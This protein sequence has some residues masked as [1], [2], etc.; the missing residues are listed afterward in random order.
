MY[1]STPLFPAF[2]RSC[3]RDVNPIPYVSAP[4]V[5][6]RPIADYGP[7]ANTCIPF[8]YQPKQ[9]N[10]GGLKFYYL[11][12]PFPDLEGNLKSHPGKGW[13]AYAKTGEYYTLW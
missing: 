13:H 6:C 2:Q 5:T 10:P 4:D 7:E 11:D 9:P 12:Y 8:G 1:N 3:L